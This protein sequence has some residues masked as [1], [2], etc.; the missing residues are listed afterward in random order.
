MFLTSLSAA[1]YAVGIVLRNVL[2]MCLCISLHI[3]RF[4]CTLPYCSETQS[5]LLQ[6]ILHAFR[7]GH[8][9]FAFKIA[10]WPIVILYLPRVALVQL[11]LHTSKLTIVDVHVALFS[12][13]PA[14]IVSQLPCKA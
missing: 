14:V 10:L 9:P 12:A 2:P 3:C 5:L 4:D 7:H 6:N 11:V 8:L 1:F 13:H